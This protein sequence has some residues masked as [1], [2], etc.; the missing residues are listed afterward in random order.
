MCVSLEPVSITD[1]ATISSGPK[2]ISCTELGVR[3]DIQFPSVS[4]SVGPKISSVD[5][6]VQ[7]AF[8]DPSTPDDLAGSASDIS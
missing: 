7:T 2:E 5:Q 4:V 8:F 1:K 6:T 3:T